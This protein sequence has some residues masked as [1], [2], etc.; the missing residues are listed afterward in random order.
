MLAC[1]VRPIENASAAMSSTAVISLSDLILP[2]PLAR[3]INKVA[4]METN[5]SAK[6][7]PTYLSRIASR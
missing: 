2:R 7:Y 4:I 1:T 5:L 3:L 6:Q